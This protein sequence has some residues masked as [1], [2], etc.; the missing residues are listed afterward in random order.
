MALIIG[1]PLNMDGTEGRKC[2]SVR[3][4]AKELLTNIDIDLIFWDER[5]TTKSAKYILSKG[6]LSKGKKKLVVDRIAASLILENA[7]GFIKNSHD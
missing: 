1:L 5:L 3:D 2:Q 4:F 6:N 7:L